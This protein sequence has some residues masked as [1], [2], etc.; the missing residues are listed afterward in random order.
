MVKNNL[1]Y[2][3][4][5]LQKEIQMLIS[6]PK[7]GK[8]VS[9][10]AEKC[11][12]C[13][14]FFNGQVSEQ[15]KESIKTD[16]HKKKKYSELS[17]N[18][19]DELFSQFAND[20]PIQHKVLSSEINR[21]KI[22]LVVWGILFG[23]WVIDILFYILLKIVIDN[24]IL[25]ILFGVFLAISLIIT[26]FVAVLKLIDKFTRQGTIIAYKSY[27]DWLNKRN[28]EG[29]AEILLQ[30]AKEKSMYNDLDVK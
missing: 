11:L 15:E 12:N 22:M 13:G 26:G 5:F 25:A 30:N 1:F 29:F 24:V 4:I 27:E 17:I 8:P 2:S 23:V 28:I 20:D 7:C 9:D 16:N 19:Q 18:E 21:A 10:K 14:Y 6:C 3:Q